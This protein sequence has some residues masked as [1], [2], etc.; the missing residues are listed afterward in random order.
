MRS[1]PQHS[2]QTVRSQV[3][4]LA[5]LLMSL[6]EDLATEI[7]KKL[8]K[9]DARR[10]L[11]AMSAL[12]KIDQQTVDL[13]Q[14]EFKDI[15][16]AFNGSSSDG[17]STARRIIQKAFSNEDAKT[18]MSSLPRSIPKCFQDAEGVDG[19]IL[20]Q[21]IQKEH[22][23]T[24]AL[25]LGYLSPQKASDITKHMSGQIR[26]D[27]LI[28]LAT[29]TEVDPVLLDEIDEVLSNAIATARRHSQLN[30][31]GSKRT[32]EILA[33]LNP[34]HRQ[35]LL[36]EIES[37]SP[38][39]GANIRAGM[40]TFEDIQKLTRNDVEILLRSIDASD[41]ELALRRCSKEVA[42]LFFA[43]MSERRAEQVKDNIAT[44]KPVSIAKIDDAQRKI[45]A[46]AADLIE[47]GTLMDPLDEVV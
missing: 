9:D 16:V 24:I 1:I 18:L 31:G 14:L 23:Q 35:K 27:V 33:Q 20:W 26:S 39:L 5:I 36:A 19:K 13:I 30:L 28:K 47:K 37:S 25:I 44:T 7:L 22:P 8:P 45:A 15:I 6:G 21:I 11:N 46:K 43:A 3:E 4:K 32:A 41:L 12:G 40:F 38:E 42:N 29:I 2:T 34:Q 17:A 10:I